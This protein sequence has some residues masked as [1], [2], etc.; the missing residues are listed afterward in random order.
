MTLPWSAEIA[1]L[2]MWREMDLTQQTGKIQK[3]FRAHLKAAYDRGYQDGF[4]SCEAATDRNLKEQGI[5]F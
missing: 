5:S 4:N 2:D 1:M 3:F